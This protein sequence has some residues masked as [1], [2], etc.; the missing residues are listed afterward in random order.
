MYCYEVYS[1]SFVVTEYSL[2]YG[3][4][5]STLPKHTDNVNLYHPQGNQSPEENHYKSQFSPQDIPAGA[6]PP[7]SPHSRY[8]GR[9]IYDH[10]AVPP[11]PP[12]P[13][14]LDNRKSV[15]DTCSLL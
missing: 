10:E 15:I 9:Y 11:R 3:T 4:M 1:M 2:G 12:L 5:Q 13:S 8:D 6:Y 7:N 14:G